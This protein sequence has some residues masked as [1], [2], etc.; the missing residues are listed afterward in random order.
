MEGHGEF[1]IQADVVS[2]A[3]SDRPSF[4]LERNPFNA[5]AGPAAF[6]E[7]CAR[8]KARSRGARDRSPKN[9][10]PLIGFT[11]ETQPRKVRS[12]PRPPTRRRV[13]W[14]ETTPLL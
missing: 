7:R 11:R 13:R 8:F 5:G 10:R 3:H 9:A 12:S 2:L 6:G 14:K 1:V 4:E